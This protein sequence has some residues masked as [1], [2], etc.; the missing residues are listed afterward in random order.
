MHPKLNDDVT[1]PQ[2][3]TKSKREL[4]NINE[5]KV[6]YKDRFSRR[7]KLAIEV[8]FKFVKF[9]GDG[10]LRNCKRILQWKYVRIETIRIMLTD[11]FQQ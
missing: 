3:V 9:V 7:Q 4:E 6:Q 2:R 11:I 1:K 5:R 10:N 8:V